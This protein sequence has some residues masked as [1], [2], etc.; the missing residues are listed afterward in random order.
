MNYK[1]IYLDHAATTPIDSRVKDAM[2]PFWDEKFGNA[3]G[4]YEEGRL[5]K[6]AMQ[7]SRETI[8]KFIGAKPDEIIFTSGGT[9]S[10]NLAVF[11]VAEA[12]LKNLPK[13]EIFQ[14]FSQRD[15]ARLSNSPAGEYAGLKKSSAEAKIKP[16]IITTKF[17]HHAVLT[18]CEQL[19]REGLDVTFLD[20]GE[21]GIVNPEDV[22]KVLR[23]ETVLVSI[24]YANNEIGTIQPIAEIG[25]IIK[26]FRMAKAQNK[27][28]PYFHTDACQAAGYLDLNVNNLGVDLMTVNGSKIY[29]PKGIGFLYK[30]TG[31]KIKPQIIGGG[32]EMRMRSGTENILLIVGMAKAFEIAQAERE[33]E[34]DRLTPLRNYFISEIVK[35]IPKVVLN[36]HAIKRL[37]NNVN[38]SILDI[39]GEALVLYMDAKGISFSTGSACTSESLDPSHVIL[40]LGKP[41]EFAHSSMRFTMGRSTTKEELD[42]VLE[43]LPATVEWLRKVSPVSIDMNAKSM[44]H[45]EVFAGENLMVKAKSKSYK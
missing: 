23:P 18:P 4:L 19:A 43:V 30:K 31:V 22:R 5:A 26:D 42:K 2:E 40:A 8:T 27:Q 37:P 14:D 36:G 20:V 1:R 6:E 34:T 29:G 16:H 39:E 24:M 9:E 35:K 38:V 21:D 11:G 13:A 28:Y 41:Y 25:K 12:A 7:N 3:G 32:Q 45:P 33:S 17:E 44:S 15:G 10:D